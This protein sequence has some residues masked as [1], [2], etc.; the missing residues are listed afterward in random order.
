MREARSWR[1]KKTARFSYGH[2]VLFCDCFDIDAFVC[3]KQNHKRVRDRMR[4]RFPVLAGQQLFAH[5]H[6]ARSC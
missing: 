1:M 5:L 2:G 4:L 3:I 6:E